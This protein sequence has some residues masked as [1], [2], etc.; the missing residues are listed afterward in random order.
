MSWVATAVIGGAVI[1]GVVQSKSADK[2]ASAQENASAQATATQLEMFDKSREDT[3]PWREAGAKALNLLAGGTTYGLPKPVKEDFYTIQNGAPTVQED[4]RL[5]GLTGRDRFDMAS[6]LGVS[7]Q[8]GTRQQSNIR[9]FDQ[10]G[11]DQAY[12]KYLDSGVTTEGMI[13][14]G[15]GEFIP[16]EDPG[17]KFGYQEFVEKPSLRAASAK[18][19]LGGGRTLKELSRYA[20]DYAST[21]YDNFLSRW[22]QSL[23]PLQSMSGVGQTT[24]TQQSANALATG[25][26]IGQNMIA[27]GNARA[28]GYINQGNIWGNV[29][30]GL[31]QNALDAYYMNKYNTTPQTP[32]I[33]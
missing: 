30:G 25:Q 29:A 5:Y 27:G 4:P 13:E 20:S 14:K 3:A 17:F 6:S 24:A 28:T 19:S 16:E 12:Q 1:G 23:T 18:G 7:A 10:A 32:Q 8:G 15:P 9:V 2:A 31:G 26:A 33:N 11:Y 22:Y 21:K